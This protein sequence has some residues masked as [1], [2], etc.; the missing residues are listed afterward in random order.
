M[1]KVWVLQGTTLQR[2]TGIVWRRN[3]EIHRPQHSLGLMYKQG[4]GVPQYMDEAARWILMAAE[5]GHR[6]AYSQI[7][8]MYWEGQGLAIN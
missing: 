6:S 2:R 3:R 7:G 1:S 5:E 8:I 4:R